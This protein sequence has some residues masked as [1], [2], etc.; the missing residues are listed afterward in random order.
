MFLVQLAA[1][2][3]NP[4][5]LFEAGPTN[6]YRVDWIGADTCKHFREYI[7]KHLSKLFL[8]QGDTKATEGIHKEFQPEVSTIVREK[9]PSSQFDESRFLNFLAQVGLDQNGVT[10]EELEKLRVEFYYVN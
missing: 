2:L 7:I 9:S 10:E 6:L 3:A 8:C 4:N 1:V 5:E